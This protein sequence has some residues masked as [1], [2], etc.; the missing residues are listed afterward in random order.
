MD[1]RLN[2][3][4]VNALSKFAQEHRES[5]DEHLAEVVYSQSKQTVKMWIPQLEL[6]SSDR[7]ILL[8]PTAWL[9]DSII[10]GAQTLLKKAC[11]V[12]G[13]QSV[14][15]GLTMTFAIQQGEFIQVL[16]TGQGHW[17]TIST[18]G[19]SHPTVRVYDS[20]YSCAGTHLK[21]QIAAVLATEKPEFVLE[22]MD[23]PI[24]SGSYDCGL[25]AIAFAT[26]LALGEKPELFFF[27]QWNMR[28]HLRQCLES[29][30][31]KMFP[32]LRKRRVKKSAVK[33]TEEVQVYCKC[34]MPELP[35]EQ[36]IE[37]TNCKEWYHVDT[38]IDVPPTTCLDSSVP[39]F[40]HKCL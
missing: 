5:W 25:F 16:N 33:T 30:E 15:C 14:S 27:D 7:E 2:Q 18:I 35:G 39:W 20:L 22:F 36:L 13:L 19:T 32:V 23:V 31:M 34:R 26:A 17:V 10:D 6:S 9:T 11:P 24:Q 21:A 4:L 1:E 28:A 3:T 37:C 38:C 40:C 12:P 29:G 8:S